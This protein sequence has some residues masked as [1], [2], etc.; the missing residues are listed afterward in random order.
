MIIIVFMVTQIL[1]E[2]LPI[3][4][5]GHLWLLEKILIALGIINTPIMNQ[6]IDF[7][8]NGPTALVLGSY[9]FNEWTFLLFN[10]KRIWRL[11]IKLSML[12]FLANTVTCCFFL[13]F[14]II[15]PLN[16]SPSIGFLITALLLLSLK[17]V[18]RKNYASISNRHAA[19]IGCAQG[20]ALLPGI[21]R[22]AATMVVGIWLGLRPY[23]SFV[24]SC[25]L[26]WPLIVAAFCKGLYDCPSDMHEFIQMLSYKNS[27]FLFILLFGAYLLLWFTEFLCRKNKLSLLGYYMFIPFLISL[28]L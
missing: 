11:I 21:S 26:Q 4:S 16:F 28:F 27:F 20:I 2:S 8:L 23:K 6:Y 13:L 1:L 22:L 12:V 18:K 14:K 5:S 17:V 10:F 19:L 7:L 15:V 24:F 9:F 3:S 25:T